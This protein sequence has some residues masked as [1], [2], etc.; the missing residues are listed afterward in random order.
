VDFER[1]PP[2]NKKTLTQRRILNAAAGGKRPHPMGAFECSLGA[3][4]RT[5]IAL[6]ASEVS[7][8]AK[9]RILVAFE[10]DCEA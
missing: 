3:K 6:E 1:F 9:K 5:Q 8:G 2:Q 4:K 10:I 7:S